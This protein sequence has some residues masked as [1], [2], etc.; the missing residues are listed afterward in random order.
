MPIPPLAWVIP[1]ALLLLCIA[2]LPLKFSHWWES[3]RNKG[4]VAV[5]IALP[6][7]AYYLAVALGKLFYHLHEYISFIVLLWSLFTIS[8]GI[9]LRGNLAATAQWCCWACC[10]W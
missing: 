2:I 3:N 6:V 4:I 1:F 9:V 8:G 10:R 5:M 7:A